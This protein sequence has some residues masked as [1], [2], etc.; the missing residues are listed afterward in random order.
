M[1]K[2]K[3]TRVVRDTN[4]VISALLFGGTPGKLISLWKAGVIRPYM[5]SGILNEYLKVL[6]YPRFNLNENEI[7]YLLYREILPYFEIVS[8]TKKSNRISSDP[9]DDKFLHCA[10]SAKANFIISG[11]CHL[12]SLKSYHNIP[13]V[14]GP[15]FLKNQ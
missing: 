7:E 2:E 14:T 9:S 8:E 1:G 4:V 11:D 10:V 13:I 15:Q 3:V 6:A 5:N 12:L